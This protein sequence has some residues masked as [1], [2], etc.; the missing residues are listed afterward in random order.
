MFIFTGVYIFL[1]AFFFWMFYD[2]VQG[3][4]RDWKRV[5]AYNNNV[6]ATNPFGDN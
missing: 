1:G 6:G 5:D 3:I 4:R 2:I